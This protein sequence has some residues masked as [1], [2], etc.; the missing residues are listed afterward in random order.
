MSLRQ[1]L[2]TKEFV[3][4]WID[5]GG[6]VLVFLDGDEISIER[7]V[8]GVESRFRTSGGSRGKTPYGSQIVTSESKAEQRRKHQHDRFFRKVIEAMGRA[9]GFLILGP[10]E[11]KLHFA[12]AIRKEPAL[13]TRL[14]KVETSDRMTERQL[15]AKVKAFVGAQRTLP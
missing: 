14:R 1:A 10:G 11:T 2:I 8:S 5:S 3:G 12:A 13:S 15:V 4:I 7:I 6:A 9:G